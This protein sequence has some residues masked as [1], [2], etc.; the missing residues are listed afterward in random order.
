MII[1]IT[2]LGGPCRPEVK[3]TS[4]KHCKRVVTGLSSSAQAA[5]VERYFRMYSGP[6]RTPLLVW[7]LWGKAVDPRG[8]FVKAPK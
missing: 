3:M 1:V 4:R 5:P 2:N 8:R 6:A 7:T